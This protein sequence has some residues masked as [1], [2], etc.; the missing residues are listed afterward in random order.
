MAGR[1]T[2][3]SAENLD[4][5]ERFTRGLLRA[6]PDTPCARA[7]A[8]VGPLALW[9][10]MGELDVAELVLSGELPNR[11]RVAPE[12]RSLRRD[13]QRVLPRLR[14]LGGRLRKLRGQV[15]VTVSVEEAV[16]LLDVLLGQLPGVSEQSGPAPQYLDGWLSAQTRLRNAGW[17]FPQVADLLLS[18]NE[19]WS[20]RPCESLVEHYGYGDDE[21]GNSG[22]AQLIDRLKKLKK[23]RSTKTGTGS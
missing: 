12:Q 22:R 16:R 23:P 13:V 3:P 8:I 18:S 7:A 5:I 2:P 21:D 10:G 4:A 20:P 19:D 14:Q 17:S 6:G 1:R 11:P 9:T 15:A